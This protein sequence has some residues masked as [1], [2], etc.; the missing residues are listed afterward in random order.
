MRTNTHKLWR[1]EAVFES[2]SGTKIRKKPTL[3]SVFLCLG[4][5]WGHD[6]GFEV[7]RAIYAPPRN[8]DRHLPAPPYLPTSSDALHIP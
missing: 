1:L 2:P 5:F 8:Q 4:F 3:W 6:L 7:M